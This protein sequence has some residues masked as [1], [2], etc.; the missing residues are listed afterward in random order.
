[1]NYNFNFNFP[2]IYSNAVFVSVDFLKIIYV[3][4]YNLPSFNRE[5]KIYNYIYSI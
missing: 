2:L 3:M 4:F 1:M 5:L